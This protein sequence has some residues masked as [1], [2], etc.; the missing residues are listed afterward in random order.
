MSKVHLGHHIDVD[1]G[2]DIGDVYGQSGH[3][4]LWLILSLLLILGLFAGG[5]WV[6]LGKP[7]LGDFI[8]QL[9][10]GEPAPMLDA[11]Q[12]MPPPERGS[13]IRPLDNAPPIAT[14][15]E[16]QVEPPPVEA[17]ADAAESAPP[18]DD[19]ERYVDWILNPRTHADEPPPLPSDAA[20]SGT[21]RPAVDAPTPRTASEKR[22]MPF[23][24]PTQPQT[25]TLA[26]TPLRPSIADTPPEPRV[27]P[28]PVEA[29]APPAP[30]EVEIADPTAPLEETPE[31]G[32]PETVAEA[33]EEDSVERSAPRPEIPEVKTPAAPSAAESPQASAAA[34]PSPPPAD[35]PP[36]ATPVKEAKKPSTPQ[37]AEPAVADKPVAPRVKPP[38]PAPRAARAPKPKP[39]PAAAEPPRDSAEVELQRQLQV[40]DYL[41]QADRLYQQGDFA[42][43][44]RTLNRI[45]KRYPDSWDAKNAENIIREIKQTAGDLIE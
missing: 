38:A 21:Q 45:A 24:S 19:T 2:D 11:P 33:P 7:G 25:E 39:A 22:P 6:M 18:R 28:T 32:L 8:R 27:A 15:T 3:P 26:D 16:P 14:H 36:Q 23:E 13:V 10:L 41:R 30:P 29:P 42:G 35:Q 12:E 40:N 9:P 5:Y 34:E 4:A 20:L 31:T 44:I 17:A 43:A 1:I 37:P